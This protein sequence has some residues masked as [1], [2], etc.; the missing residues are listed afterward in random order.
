MRK[1]G[2]KQLSALVADVQQSTDAGR[3]RL[4]TQLLVSPYPTL[5]TQNN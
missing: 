2:P 5:L 4:L 1:L 3:E